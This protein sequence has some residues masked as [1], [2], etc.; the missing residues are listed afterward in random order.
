MSSLSLHLDGL[1]TDRRSLDE[2]KRETVVQCLARTSRK[3]NLPLLSGCDVESLAL[4][5]LFFAEASDVPGLFTSPTLGQSG[6]ASRFLESGGHRMSVLTQSD[7]CDNFLHTEDGGRPHCVAGKISVNIQEATVWHSDVCGSRGAA[8]EG[9]DLV[10]S[11]CAQSL[12]PDI[13]PRQTK[14]SHTL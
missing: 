6:S 3:D 8:D 4:H 10:C 9:L 12:P 5:R 14:S 13:S 2:K 7:P 1:R 11:G